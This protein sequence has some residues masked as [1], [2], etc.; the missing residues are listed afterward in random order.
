MKIK[1][2]EAQARRLNLLKESNDPVA[3]IEQYVKIKIGF[4]D[5]LY[6]SIVNLSVYELLTEK[7]NFN[8]KANSLMVISDEISLLAR[9]AYSYIHD[10]PDEGL[11]QRIDYAKETMD[12]KVDS[13]QLI[14]SAIERVIETEEDYKV[15][16]FFKSSGPMDITD[17]Q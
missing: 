1:I 2:T 12:G 17:I 10:L 14:I 8:E 3:R 5:N 9:Q 11:D 15:T 16:Q 4:V 6:D 13:L 7:I